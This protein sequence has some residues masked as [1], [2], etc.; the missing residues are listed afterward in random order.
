MGGWCEVGGKVRKQEGRKKGEG[1]E[2]RRGGEEETFK[3]EQEEG[4]Q[5]VTT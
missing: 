3:R 2:G 4:H 5:R 1:R